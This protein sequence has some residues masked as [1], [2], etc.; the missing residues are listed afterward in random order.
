MNE[1]ASFVSG[2]PGSDDGNQY[3]NG[4]YKNKLNFPPFIPHSL[5]EYKN[6]IGLFEKTICMTGSQFN[7]QT[8]SQE[9]HYNLHSLY[10]LSQGQPTL[11][12]CQAATGQRCLI[13]SRS[14][15]PGAQKHVG[16]W[17]GDNSS[18]WRHLKQGLIATIEF[19]LFGFP[20]TG[21]DI[22]GFFNEAEEEMCL[23]WSQLGAFFVYSR[24][25]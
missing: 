4:C 11:E 15:F 12:A 6:G 24:L 20:Y 7:P 2:R 16:H 9:S 19:S 23:R 10:G 18:I 25:D 21:P 8:G 14:T 22:C 5:N 13:V 1:P 3:S 17:H